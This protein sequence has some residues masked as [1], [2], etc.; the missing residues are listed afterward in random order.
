M[1]CNANTSALVL[2]CHMSGEK[3]DMRPAVNAAENLDTLSSMSSSLVVAFGHV[4]LVILQT[5]IEINP[6]EIDP[7]THDVMLTKYAGVNVGTKCLPRVVT[8]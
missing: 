3:A 8:I 7:N 6:H 5:I 1:L 4:H 2:Y